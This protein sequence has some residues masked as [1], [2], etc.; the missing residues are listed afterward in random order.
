MSL[1]RRTFIL[2]I[3]ALA[4]LIGI[5][6]FSFRVDASAQVFQQIRAHDNPAINRWSDDTLHAFTDRLVEMRSNGARPVT[7]AQAQAKDLPAQWTVLVY[8]AAD[9]DLE[10]YALADL[11]E[12]EFIGSTDEVSVVV[13]LDRAAGYDT[14]Q[15]DWTEARRY[16]VEAG[17]DGSIEST[18]I[19]RLGET[20]TGD[21]QT[22]VD[23]VTWGMEAF[24]AENY[25]LV[26]WNH[27]GGWYGVASD[28][29]HDYDDLTLQELEQA[30]SQIHQASGG[31]KIDL[32]GFDACLMGM[33]EVYQTLAPY[34]SYAV[35]SADLVPG[36]GWAYA[37][38]LTELTDNPEMRAP[39]LGRVIVDKFTDFYSRSRSNFDVYSMGVINLS[40]IPTVTERLVNFTE[41]VAEEP[42]L[43]LEAIA[44][45]RSEAIAHGGFD[46]PQYVDIWSAIDLRTFMSS[47]AVTSGDHDLAAA[48]RF[49]LDAA[50]ESVVYYRSSESFSE[51]SA[52]SIYF[53]RTLR[54]YQDED[55]AAR[56]EEKTQELMADWR[57]FLSTFYDT[58]RSLGNL[59]IGGGLLGAS[60]EREQ[61]LID[62]GLGESGLIDAAF[63]VSYIAEDNRP[64]LIDYDRLGSSSVQQVRWEPQIPFISDGETEIPILL[65]IN[66]QD[67]TQ[68]V[69]N[70]TYYPENG[71]GVEAQ[72]IIDLETSAVVS[73]W[74]IRRT[75]A[76]RMPF[77]VSPLNGERF[78]PSWIELGSSN[79]FVPRDATDE[80]IFG[81]APF[82]Y[83]LREAEEGSYR[84]GY[85]AQSISGQAVQDDAELQVQQSGAL[86]TPTLSITLPPAT[87]LDTD[88]DGV[89]DTADNCP[90]ISNPDQRDVDGDGIGDACDLINNLP[91]RDGDGVPDQFDNC[92]TVPNPTQAD[93]N[94]NGIGNACEGDP[95]GDGI[96]VWDNCP[97][98]YNP[99]QRDSDGDFIGDACDP[100]PFGS[101]P[102][103]LDS[104]GDGLTDEQELALG[105]DPF[106]M[107]TDG[108]GVFDGEEVLLYGTN[109][110]LWDTDGD[111]LSD[112]QEVSGTLPVFTSP[113]L[114]D[115]DGDGIND[116]EQ[117]YGGTFRD[118]DGDGLRDR[119]EFRLGT[120]PYNPDSDSDGLSDGEEVLIF[121]TNP[122]LWD[123]DYDGIPDG[124]EVYRF[125]TNPL[126]VDTDGDGLSD[127]LEVYVYGTN[128][129][130]PDVGFGITDSDY[131]GIPDDEEIFF[132][133]TDPF[134]PDTD[135]DG[136]TD[137]E[138]IFI[139]GF[140][141]FNPDTNGDGIG[142]LE[143]AL[144]DA[145]SDGDGLSDY[146]E[147]RFYN[148]NPYN[149]DSDGD[150]LDDGLEVFEFETSPTDPDTDGDGLLDGQEVAMGC[151]PLLLDTDDDGLS[152]WDEYAIWGTNCAYADTDLDG[153]PDAV[154]IYGPT[155]PLIADTDGDGLIDGDEYEFMTDPL[156]PDTDEDGLLDGEEVLYYGT[157][158]LNPDTDGDGLTDLE[159]VYFFLTSPLLMDTDGDG[160]S[161]YDEVYIYGTD[162]LN[163]DTDSDGLTDG[164]EINTYGTDPFNPD[165]DGDGILDGDEVAGGTD[166][167]VPNGSM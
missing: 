134:N 119:D 53:P 25:A 28:A 68:G 35:A 37:P 47:V 140:D 24:P 54:A 20:N 161:D 23:F 29:S 5:S 103:A 132:W 18:E 113:L 159:E 107:D 155:D 21:P 120:D 111:G 115:T 30:L 166:P 127:Y 144:G 41:V 100:T 73:V 152:D 151:S 114:A 90:L 146:E 118:S 157:D 131:D 109:P 130:Q 167:L 75:S 16:F 99:D 148:T 3:G 31:R 145:D 48:A 78:V 108:D 165:T 40:L 128:P 154:E 122:L 1:I 83:L 81:D 70:G 91:D 142:D 32:I 50:Q 162:P 139:Y 112:G 46:D 39:E 110:L 58:A 104:D 10:R 92:P 52:L 36:F 95:D 76:G 8:M 126:L 125:G 57:D 158:P 7:L 67:E 153:I 88:G 97:T 86:S 11:N 149:P 137:Y 42:A 55:R 105:T 106:D 163:L 160:L 65:I 96:R 51:G 62:L 156:N 33:L 133:G 71:D 12:M 77:E 22:L 102:D 85:A 43:A 129:L 64:I 150:G 138:E 87:L 93:T 136:L 72:L 79:E 38:M 135:G 2:L 94:G 14:S 80:L 4:L 49:V 123:T 59:D 117:I 63:Y 116:Y 56:Y 98:V 17:F 13:Q 69:I 44:T 124:E 61:L 101:G 34:A 147:I 9:N 141:P 60:S 84:I 74:G 121:G 66:R 45:A 164:A 26:I 15:G 19:E 6:A 27:G 143:T 89:P 82:R